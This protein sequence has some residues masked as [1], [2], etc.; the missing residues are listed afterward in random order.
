MSAAET[1]AARVDAVLEQRTRLRGQQP[2][3]DLFAGLPPDHQLLT[4][5][6][7]RT[8]EANLA[9]IA[10]YVSADDVIVDVGGGAGRFGLPLALRAGELINVDPSAAMLAAFEKNAQQ[11]GITNVRAIHADWLDVEPPRGTLALVNH[12]TYLTRD[13]VTFIR[14]LEEAASRRVVI[15]VGSPPPP[16]RNG[17]LFALV[18][19]EP[20]QSVPG[21]VELVNVLWELGIEPDVRMLPDRWGAPT[22]PTGEAAMQSAMTSVRGHQWAFWPLRPEVQARAKELIETRFDEL[23]AETPEGFAPRWAV[24][25]RE[26]LITWEL[27]A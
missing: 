18:H 7:R 9:L 5:D 26:V 11:A 20:S 27:R 23:F 4:A 25:G 10:E 21:H 24:P 19:G 14:K 2:P 13:I 8:P 22:S 6:P 17:A 15:T 1:Y 16:A 12:V 3:G